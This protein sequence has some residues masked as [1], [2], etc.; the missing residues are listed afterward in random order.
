MKITIDIFDL[1]LGS[2]AAVVGYNRIYGG[3][4]GKLISKGLLPDTPFVVLDL[5]AAGGGVKV[6]L[7]DKI[8]TLS[9]PEANAL[10]IE[11]ITRDDSC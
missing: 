9:K 8:V 4:I 6:M 3:Y 11:E 1:S 5:T 10:C 2:V 7:S